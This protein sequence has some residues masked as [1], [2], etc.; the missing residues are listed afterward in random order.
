MFAVEDAG[1]LAGIDF[2]SR[3]YAIKTTAERVLYNKRVYTVT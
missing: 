1:S 2:S 3:L